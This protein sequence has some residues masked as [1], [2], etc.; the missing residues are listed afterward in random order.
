VVADAPSAGD[1][2]DGRALSGDAGLMLDKLLR[3]AGIAPV[4]YATS[5][6][7]CRPQGRRPRVGEIRECSRW[8]GAE[9]E[10]GRPRFILALGDLASRVVVG[11]PLAESAGRP[12]P[13]VRAPDGPPIPAMAIS[14]PSKLLRG[15]ATRVAEAVRLLRKHVA[16]IV[17]APT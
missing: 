11:L 17:T 7:K 16:P 2:L 12:L 8:L 3:S 6:V 10:R 4:Y 14:H 1:E 15:R 5:A 9:L 13:C